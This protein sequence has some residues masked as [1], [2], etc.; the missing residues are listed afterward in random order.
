MIAATAGE[1]SAQARAR[2]AYPGIHVT[3]DTSEVLTSPDIDAIAV[4]DGS[5]LLDIGGEV[6][7]AAVHVP[8]SL[9]GAELEIR[10]V[11]EPW[12][13]PPQ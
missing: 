12:S 3:A 4:I 13:V 2:K 1:T 6:G 9:A 11:G 5:V 8:A 10:P 7:A